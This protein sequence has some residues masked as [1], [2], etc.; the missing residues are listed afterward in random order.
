MFNYERLVLR[1]YLQYYSNRWGF[2]FFPPIFLSI[3]PLG[4]W[5]R[6]TYTWALILGPCSLQDTLI[7]FFRL[8]FFWK[9]IIL[10]YVYHR[11]LYYIRQGTPILFILLSVRL[12]QQLAYILQNISFFIQ[13]LLRI[14]SFII[15]LNEIINIKWYRCVKY[16]SLFFK[17]Q[18]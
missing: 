18:V 4:H 14:I 8:T 7:T 13:N 6:Q 15:W 12:T 11:L 1:L 3:V 17:Q 5:R 16:F 9:N 10:Q 2:Y